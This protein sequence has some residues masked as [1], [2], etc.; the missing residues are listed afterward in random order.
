MVTSSAD[1]AVKGMRDQIWDGAHMGDMRKTLT[2]A[3]S[4]RAR[5]LLAL[6]RRL[7]LAALVVVESW[8]RYSNWR[9]EITPGFFR[10]VG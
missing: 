9:S 8:F 7:Y 2:H 4:Y 6:Q 1:S 3:H 5:Y 10:C